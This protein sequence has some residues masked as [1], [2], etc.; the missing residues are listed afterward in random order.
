MNKPPQFSSYFWAGYECTSSLPEDRNRLDMLRATKHDQYC[1]E[2]YRLAKSIGISTVREG[3]AW[4]RIDKGNNAYDFARYE[5]ILKIGQEENIQQIWD[6]NHFDF[7]GYLNAFSDKFVVQF[8]EYARRSIHLIRKYQQGTIYIAPINEISFFTWI[9]ADRGNWAPYRKGRKNG[10]L[11]KKQLVKA[12]I[13]AMDA[14]WSEDA[15]VQFIQVDPFMRRK[16]RE[17]ANEQALAHVKEFNSVIM[18][19]AWDM[20]YGKTYPELGGDPKYLQIA[21]INYYIYNQEWVVSKKRGGIGHRMMSWTDKNRVHLKEL[22]R[23]VHERYNCNLV[24]TE[25]GSYGD[26]RQRWWKRLL[27]EIGDIRKENTLPL[28]GVCAYPVLDRPDWTNFLI[29][30][31]GLWDFKSDDPECKRIPHEPSLN[32]V[33]QYINEWNKQ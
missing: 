2:D 13:A 9:G 16:A 10:L 6:L 29:P 14:I 24:I 28:S 33:M 1:R 27:S 12:S 7:P 8:A 20:L 5:A 26:L 19:E 25:T 17:P 32:L 3:L 22:L 21:G 31:S 30:N 15:D 18:Y 11:F 23:E 4:S